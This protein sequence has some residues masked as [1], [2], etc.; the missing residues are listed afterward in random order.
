MGMVG[1]SYTITALIYGLFIV[2]GT[3]GIFMLAKDYDNAASVSVMQKTTKQ[4]AAKG[5]LIKEMTGP[6]IPFFFAMILNN[7]HLGFFMT[8]W[9]TSPPTSSMTP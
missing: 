9:P 5:S 1:D 8:C 7:M 3:W 4:A 2:G 6:V